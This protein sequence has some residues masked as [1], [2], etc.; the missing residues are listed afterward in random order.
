VGRLVETVTISQAWTWVMALFVAVVTIDKGIDIFKKWHGSSPEG[1]LSNLV[2]RLS[3]RLDSV[4]SLVHRHSELLAN[5]K[6]R[7]ETIENGTHVTQEALLALLSHAIDGD[8]KEQLVKARND[9][10]EYLITKK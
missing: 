5:D 8:N 9:L 10:H 4:E 2:E 1:K 7:F 3:E 6:A